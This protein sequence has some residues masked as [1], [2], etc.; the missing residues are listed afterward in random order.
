VE[1][2]LSNGTESN[3][4]NRGKGI[5]REEIVPTARTMNLSGE[6]N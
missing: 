6:K 2:R 4:L 5:G 3:K 1:S